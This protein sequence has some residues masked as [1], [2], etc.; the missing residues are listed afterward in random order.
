MLWH[1][2]SHGL[3]Q[4]ELTRHL[5]GLFQPEIG[6]CTSRLGHTVSSSSLLSQEYLRRNKSVHIT[7]LRK[8]LQWMI[9]FLESG[10]FLRLALPPTLLPEP[11]P[12]HM[13]QQ[14]YLSTVPRT[15]HNV[16][17]LWASFIPSLGG[18]LPTPLV[19]CLIL[20]VLYHSGTC[21]CTVSL[22]TSLLWDH[23]P[24]GAHPHPNT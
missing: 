17:P 10:C 6:L 13:T 14:Y 15:L 20:I 9:M 24:L 5:P 2:F 19:F 18:H 3:P 1:W 7:P 11:S 12:H 22:S 4:E 21:S 8:T 16:L 23:A